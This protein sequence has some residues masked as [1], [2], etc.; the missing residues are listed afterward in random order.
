MERKH[1][2]LPKKEYCFLAQVQL[3]KELEEDYC[4]FVDR[5]NK[6]VDVLIKDNLEDQRRYEEELEKEKLDAHS[7]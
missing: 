6:I 1:R 2:N 4:D 3:N 5:Q 7:K